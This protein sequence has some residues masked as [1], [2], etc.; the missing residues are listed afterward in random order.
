MYVCFLLEGGTG[1]HCDM[2]YSGKSSEDKLRNVF[3]LVQGSELLSQ[4]GYYTL[5]L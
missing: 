1:A 5:V 4:R 3:D 2:I